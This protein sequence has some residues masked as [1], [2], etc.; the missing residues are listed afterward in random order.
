MTVRSSGAPSTGGR[1]VRSGLDAAGGEPID[2]AGPE[3]VT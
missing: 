2:V 1:V 3:R